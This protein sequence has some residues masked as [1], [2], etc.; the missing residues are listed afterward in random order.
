MFKTVLL[1][2]ADTNKH[3]FSHVVVVVVIFPPVV[4]AVRDLSELGGSS[5]SCLCGEGVK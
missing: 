5:S 2:W 1:E 3:R 4:V